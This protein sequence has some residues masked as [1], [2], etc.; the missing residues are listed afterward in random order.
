VVITEINYNYF[1]FIDISFGIQA[2]R[3][4]KK[5][6]VNLNNDKPIISESGKLL[7]FK[8]IW[9]QLNLNLADLVH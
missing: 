8:L 4:Q 7:K 1:V 5:N 2:Y 6:Y 3:Y 9:L